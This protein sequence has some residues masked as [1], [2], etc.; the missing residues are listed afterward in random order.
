MARIVVVGSTNTDM[1]V[2]APRLP[3]PGETVLGGEFAV[4]AGGKGANQAVAAARLGA[5]VA[6]IGCVGLDDLGERTLAALAAEGIDIRGVRRD[7]H[8]ASGVAL[9]MVDD[10]G[11][12]QIAVAPGANARLTAAD[13]EAAAAI[14]A[15]ADSLV[16]QLEVPL[17]AV[18]R[19]ME[20]ARRHGRRV[21]LN[22]APARPVPAAILAGADVITPNES[23]AAALLGEYPGP[24]AAAAALLKSGTGCAIVTL[25]GDG[26]VVACPGE[27]YRVPAQRVVPVDTT[28]AGDAFSGALAVSLA[29]RMPLRQAVEFSVAAAAISVTRSGAQPSLPRRNEVLALLEGG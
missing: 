17:P 25:G 26:I 1:V 27:T 2:K 24:E 16:V 29:E 22:P 13:V 9:I 5:E 6:F 19:A 4:V 18:A 21:L 11:E 14:L 7:P 10:R 23:E 3:G 15:E 28:A 8:A 12:N 20:L